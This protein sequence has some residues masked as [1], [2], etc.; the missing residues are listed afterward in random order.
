M[1]LAD[2]VASY[3]DTFP[4]F[5]DS[6]PSVSSSGRWLNGVWLLGNNYKGSGYYGAYPPSYVKRVTAL[7]PDVTP[8]AWL[9]LFSGSLDPSVPGVRVDLRAPGD[10]VAAA[11]VRATAR[12]LP[13]RD[14]TFRMVAADPPY[15]PADAAR[16]GTPP[17]H[18]PAVLREIARVV[19]PGGFLIWLDTT[20]PLYRKVEWHHWGMICVQRSTN[21]RTR[22]CS[23]FTRQ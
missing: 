9:H 1:T 11:S 4:Q 7:F 16:Y 12:A 21:H 8:A 23:L 22:L 5:P 3:R 14:G 6:V 15:S 13:F 2:R 17:V 20:L 18:K 19:A 10:G